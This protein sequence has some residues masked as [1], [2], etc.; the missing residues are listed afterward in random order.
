MPRVAFAGTGGDR[1]FVFVVLRG[2][3]DGLA[4]V[5][6]YGDPHY[7]ALRSD[8]ALPPPGASGGVLALDDLFGLHPSLEFLAECHAAGELCVAHAVA[9]PYRERSHFDAQNV[10][11]TGAARPYALPDGW[12][13]RALGALP[14]GRASSPGV[15]LGPDVPLVMR[16]ATPVISWS[17][18]RLPP[19]DD[20]TLDRLSDL[21]AHDDVLGRRLADALSAESALPVEAASES[22]MQAPSA[23]DRGARRRRVASNGR[24]RAA[25]GEIIRAAAGFLARNDGPVAAALDIGGWDTHANERGALRLRL[26]ALDAALRSF[27]TAL[28]TTWQHTVV[29]VA[30]EFGRTAAANGTGGTDHGTAGAAFVLGGAVQGGRVIADWPGLAA[31][32]LYEGRDLRP[33]LDLRSVLKGVLGEHLGVPAAALERSVFPESRAAAPLDG[34]VKA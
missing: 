13:N 1:R 4:A 33:T 14:L 32:D 25:S 28:G 29:V 26:A 16:G 8:L 30:T 11:E 22:A 18:S 20:D 23:R 2:A 9:T 5:P 12:L 31:R 10:L 6:A 15:A 17:P 7:A 27:K 21:Y 34:L 3:L 19:V 24:A